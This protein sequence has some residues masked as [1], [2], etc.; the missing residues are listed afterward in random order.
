MEAITK[1]SWLALVAV[2]AAPAAILFRPGLLGKLYG[3]EAAGPIG[4]LLTHR[5]ALFLAVFAAALIAAFD[6]G[7]RQAASVVAAIS[8]VGFLAVYAN[9]GLPA[10]P[11]RSIAVVD[12]VALVPLLI[13][14]VDAWRG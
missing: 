12:A 14:A 7:S 9:A 5:G 2:H 4:I 3:V 10:G 13:V 6:P 11:L 1:A 8:V